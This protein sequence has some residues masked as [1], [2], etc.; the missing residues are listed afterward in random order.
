MHQ[1]KE[2][3]ALQ[4]K[5]E[6]TR[7]GDKRKVA[8]ALN[9]SLASATVQRAPEEECGERSRSNTGGARSMRKPFG[10]GEMHRR[11]SR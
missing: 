3:T 11:L 1:G 7:R 8:Q 6:R 10:S 9:G 2:A 5:G 4:R